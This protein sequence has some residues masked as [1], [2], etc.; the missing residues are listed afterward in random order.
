MLLISYYWPPAGGGGVFRWLKMCKFLPEYGWEPTVF[1]PTQK[2]GS[3]EDSTLLNQVE[4]INVIGIPITEPYD[5]Y[6]KF[7]GSQK[8]NSSEL[9]TKNGSWKQK[10][11]LWIRGNFFIP[12]PKVLWVTPASKYLT[13]YLKNN[14]VDLIV[15]TG[16]PHSMHLV[17]MK[18]N[19]RGIPWIADF[20]DPWSKIDFHDKLMMTQYAKNKNMALEKKVLQNCDA[21]VTV[22]RTWKQDLEKLS[23][24][25]VFLISNG[26]DPDDFIESLPKKDSKF[27]FTHVGSMNEDRN[28]ETTWRAIRNF[29]QAKQL[30]QQDFEIR[31]VGDVDQS[32]VKSI[33]KFDLSNYAVLVGPVSHQEAIQEMKLASLLYLPINQISI[34]NHGIV[35][36]KFYEYLAAER[37]ILCIG[38]AESDIAE[39]LLKSQ[40]TNA[41]LP[42]DE[43]GIAEFIDS[44]WSNRFEPQGNFAAFSRKN[45]AHEYVK[46]FNQLKNHQA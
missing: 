31:L 8:K 40:G 19:R 26:F 4:G 9:I 43:N 42:E 17:A 33:E 25:E 7:M 3:I 5:L 45:L 24:R 12:D 29:I 44:V 10:L 38:S 27:T 11:A 16:P 1:T 41:I 21:I 20:R 28:I 35:P 36:G 14:Q 46:I 23:G 34:S 30:G 2:Q 32:V 13:E 18:T 15:S 39:L 22:T 6:R 37:P